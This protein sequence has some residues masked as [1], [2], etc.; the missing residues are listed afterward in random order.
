M[1]QNEQAVDVPT[2]NVKFD[3]SWIV[4]ESDSHGYGDIVRCTDADLKWL[5]AETARKCNP[6]ENKFP[7][8]DSDVECYE[9]DPR[10]FSEDFKLLYEKR[11]EPLTV[12][13][14][15]PEWARDLQMKC[16]KLRGMLNAFDR[17]ISDWVPLLPV[18]EAE[19]YGGLVRFQT[20]MSDMP[21]GDAALDRGLKPGLYMD[22]RKEHVYFLCDQINLE[23]YLL[24]TI[25]TR[26]YTCHIKHD[27]SST[28]LA[29]TYTGDTP[30]QDGYFHPNIAAGGREWSTVC[31]GDGS[32]AFITA[33]RTGELQSAF[34]ILRQMLHT[35]GERN[36]Y[37]LLEKIFGDDEDDPIYC[38]IDGNE[39]GRQSED[40]EVTSGD[41]CYVD[42]AH[43]GTYFEGYIDPDNAW[44]EPEFFEDCYLHTSHIREFNGRAYSESIFLGTTGPDVENRHR[45]SHS[46]NSI[47]WSEVSHLRASHPHER[48]CGNATR[49][50][51]VLGIELEPTQDHTPYSTKLNDIFHEQLEDLGAAL[52]DVL[53]SDWPTRRMHVINVVYPTFG[54]D[55]EK[56]YSLQDP[57]GPAT[58]SWIANFDPG[59]SRFPI[60]FGHEM[61][62]LD[63]LV[64]TVAIRN[65]IDLMQDFDPASG[66]NNA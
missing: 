3:D 23:G 30:H 63:L 65:T 42:Y 46:L 40:G 25:V 41:P 22:S 21:A 45:A 24:P 57:L 1:T 34:E 49:V 26:F 18:D 39:I 38:I 20:M 53:P 9:A 48:W 60:D 36:P 29:A 6:P 51:S 16:A 7:D 52:R 43:S 50:E 58:P 37:L 8:I 56:M 2:E 12:F 17:K 27:T 59:D 28:P 35:N 19:V 5:A 64:A 14:T 66:E 13:G 54:A 10:S 33:V 61:I 11:L 4:R 47:H 55:G 44:W 15:K 62:P 31:M 32:T